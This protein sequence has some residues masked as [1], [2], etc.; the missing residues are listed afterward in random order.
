MSYTRKQYDKKKLKKISEETLHCYPA[1]SYY[2]EDKC[3]Y[4]RLYKSRRR[5]SYWATCKKE[6]RQKARLYAKRNNVYTKKVYDLW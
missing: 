4:V 3:R 1:G 6:A 2:D 5:T